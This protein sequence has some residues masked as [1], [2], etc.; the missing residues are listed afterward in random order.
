MPLPL[1]WKP[2]PP[3]IMR[4]VPNTKHQR[5]EG[6]KMDTVYSC[7]E[8]VK[9]QNANSTAMRS[10]SCGGWLQHWE[11]YSKQKADRCSV[12]G[13]SKRAD[14][15]AHVTRPWAKSDAYRTAPYIIPMCSSH[16]GQRGETFA[17]KAPVTFVWAN[18]TETCGRR[19]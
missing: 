2:A 8:S 5:H 9:I 14:V 7:H 1:K 10:C 4:V 16:N 12:A 18:V 17:S 3:T 15:G 6:T 13:C 11:K 19:D